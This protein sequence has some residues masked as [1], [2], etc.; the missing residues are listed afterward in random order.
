MPFFKKKK[1]EE[2]SDP[3]SVPSS[4][5]DEGERECEMTEQR[6]DWDQAQSKQQDPQ[7]EEIAPGF[8]IKGSVAQ[9]N[10]GS[11]HGSSASVRFAVPVSWH[12]LTYT[13][14]K[15]KILRGLTGTALP[16]RCLA[17]I[18]SSGAGK[19]T[20][21]N[22]ISDRLASS[23]T[24]K[25][26]GTR[27]LGDVEYRRRYRKIMGFVAQDDI[28]SRL[29]TP[30]GSL[31][32][33]LRV[34]RG[35][36]REETKQRVEETLEELRLTHCRD[37]IVGVPGLVAGLSGGE[38]KRCNIGVEL[39]CDPKIL[40]LDEP[41][42][43]L[44]SVTSVK[45]V[46]LL[47]TLA[48]TGRTVIYTIHQP[49]AETLL[50][51]DDIMLLTRGRCVYHGTMANSLAYFESIG[52]PCPERFTPTDFYMTLLQDPDVS[53]ILVKKWKKH[54]K[55]G[56]QT[57]HTTAVELSSD[58]NN[59]PT[60]KLLDECIEKYKSTPW[61]Q[62]SE[63]FLRTL[64][65]LSRD[66]MYLFANLGRSLFFGVFLGLI[67]LNLHDDV[68]G[69]QDR[70][71]LFFMVCMN[72]VMGQTFVMLHAFNA[73]KP[74]YIREQQ[75]GSYSPFLYFLTKTLV[76][77]PVRVV[78]CFFECVVLYW[79]VGFH[80]SA[81]SFFYYFGVLALLT[82]VAS[83]LGFAIGSSISNPVAAAGISPVILIPL[84]LAGGLMANTD[85]LRP[86]W[87][88]IEKP[89]F[90]RQA[91]ILLMR[92]ELKHLT[93]IR[94]DPS[95]NG[96][97]YC[98]NQPKNGEEVLHQLGF[99]ET[100]SSDWAMWVSLAVLYFLFRIIVVIALSIAARS[101]F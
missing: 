31:H 54:L 92:N 37:T 78:Y 19:T 58:P 95:G 55:Y 83:G 53:T 73:D 45:I 27:Q 32:F 96:A 98:A 15:R 80:R 12:N 30:E 4:D 36:S 48:R 11:L 74:L 71:G 39:I 38:R 60:A 21:L 1:E 56:K 77:F 101:K 22:A 81:G 26:H 82:E 91:Y 13:A 9:F 25:I 51:F 47:N 76:E 61:I 5:T 50:Y 75:V 57:P 42:S 46:N 100:Q 89:S 52:Y 49:T 33:S 18:G 17:V 7:V 93:Y 64:V 41:T 59:S 85:R 63:L 23:R 14:G 65:E 29:A 40:L 20:F 6:D 99:E 68:A 90:I 62:F 79:M 2:T 24:L 10:A 44:D 87:Y 34:R 8:T 69:I 97:E 86:Y 43:G 70:Q 35:T 67:F 84:A 28:L 72:R 66:H 94:C 16:S 3:P 88:W